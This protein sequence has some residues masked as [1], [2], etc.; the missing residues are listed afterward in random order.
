MK[1]STLYGLSLILLIFMLSACRTHTY[2]FGL[3]YYPKNAD[4]KDVQYCLH[5]NI[6]GAK[7]K[8][9]NDMT[10]KNIWISITGE[11]NTILLKREYSV[12]ARALTWEISW[13]DYDNLTISFYEEN[14]IISLTETNELN[15][16]PKEIFSVS[17]TSDP[18]SENFIETAVPD[19][20]TLSIRRE[21]ERAMKKHS[22]HLYL[23]IDKHDV[24]P[25][26]SILQETAKQFSLSQEEVPQNCANCI[27]SFTAFDFT[28][29]VTQ[30]NDK[31]KGNWII[32]LKGWD[33]EELSRSIFASL[34]KSLTITYEAEYYKSS[35]GI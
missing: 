2:T 5:V 20:V 14:G 31:E 22:A 28:M 16:I 25:V 10:K 8:A 15:Y 3:K 13:P 12:Q 32:S 33:R 21:L 18:K 27:A 30:T 19:Y 1:K 17:F 23:R 4:P 34:K 9:Y 6:N 26:L 7:G 29:S 24:K 35:T 11:N